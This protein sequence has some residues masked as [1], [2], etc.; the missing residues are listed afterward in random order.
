[1]EYYIT[2]RTLEKEYTCNIKPI[3]DIIFMEYETNASETITNK[4][5]SK[6]PS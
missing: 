1:M 3:V 2:F 5:S 6:L 4:F